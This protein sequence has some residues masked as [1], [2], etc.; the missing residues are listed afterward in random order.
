[1]FKEN[2]LL[3]LQKTEQSTFV[4][5]NAFSSPIN[6][7]CKIS[8]NHFWFKI[9]HVAAIKVRSSLNSQVVFREVL[10]KSLACKDPKGK[11][12]T[13]QDL[14]VMIRIYKFMIRIYKFIQSSLIAYFRLQNGIFK[15]MTK[16]ITFWFISFFNT[17][18]VMYATPILKLDFRLSKKSDCQ[19]YFYDS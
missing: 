8:I 14:I 15:N 18:K 19:F 12:H 10:S 11:I 9:I 4:N 7:S 13:L 6:H 1:M 2:R 17:I 5:I 3:S 16:N